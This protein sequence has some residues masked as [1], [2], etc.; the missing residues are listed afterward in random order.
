[1]ARHRATPSTRSLARD[2]VGVHPEE[3]V[4]LGIETG[5]QSSPGVVRVHR[6]HRVAERIGPTQ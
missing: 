2:G 3:P 5:L 1:M 4:I 6:P